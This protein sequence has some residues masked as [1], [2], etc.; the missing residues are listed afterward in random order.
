[1]DD[2]LYLYHHFTRYYIDDIVI[3][4]GSLSDYLIYLKTIFS[5]FIYLKVMLE[6]KKLYLAYPLVTLLG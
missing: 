1:M 6:L 3:F 2:F 5:L 4:S